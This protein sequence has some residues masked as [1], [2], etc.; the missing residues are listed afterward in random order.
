[1]GRRVNTFIFLNDEWRD[2]FG[3]HLELWNRNMTQ[4]QV[5]IAPT[6]GRFVVFSTT[7][8]SY[9]GHP[10]P[11]KAPPGRS[12]RSIAL[13]FYTA[14]C[15]TEDCLNGNCFHGHSTRWQRIPPGAV[16]S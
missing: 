12:R 2:E 16:C 7:D 10:Y 9:H 3:G 6:M 14:E 11:L 8:F 13:Y 15:P 1:M 5:R 4:C